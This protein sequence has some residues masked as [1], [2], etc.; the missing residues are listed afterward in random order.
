MNKNNIS[1]RIK[2]ETIIE[3]T[4]HTLEEWYVLIDEFDG[5][6]KGYKAIVAFLQKQHQLTI[7]WSQTIAIA[8][9]YMKGIRVANQT[10]KGFSFSI[11]RSVSLPIEKAYF[12][13]TNAHHLSQWL[14]P[15]LDIEFKVGGRFNFD[16][17]AEITF[18]KITPNKLIKLEL[19]I[20]VE[21]AISK[22]DIDFLSKKQ[23]TTLK[24][25]HT[26]LRSQNEVEEYKAYWESLLSVFKTYVK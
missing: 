3:K 17:I 19:K 23:K 6:T 4:G 2:K 9:E 25:T 26:Q 24:I 5:T 14:S 13:F 20:L 22:L 18:V 15:Y 8:Y 11:R 21:G 7:W 12:Y 10:E 16:D 1:Q